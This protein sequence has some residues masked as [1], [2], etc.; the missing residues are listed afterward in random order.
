MSEKIDNLSLLNPTISF[1]TVFVLL[2]F[3]VYFDVAL[4][5]TDRSYL[6]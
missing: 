2:I 3:A 4:L 5:L 1:R 6:I